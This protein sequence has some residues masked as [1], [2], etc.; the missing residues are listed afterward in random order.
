MTLD[1]PQHLAWT[2]RSRIY[3]GLRQLGPLI[4]LTMAVDAESR[5]STS[6]LSTQINGPISFSLRTKSS[7]LFLRKSLLYIYTHV[8]YAL[9]FLSFYIR[10]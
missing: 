8:D 10:S 2:K 9:S 5:E 4:A 6:A 7:F 3:A 1:F